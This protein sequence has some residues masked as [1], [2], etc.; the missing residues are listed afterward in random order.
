[1]CGQIPAGRPPRSCSDFYTNAGGCDTNDVHNDMSNNI[2]NNDAE[3]SPGVVKRRAA[4]ATVVK[5]TVEAS[6]AN[7]SFVVEHQT[8]SD[9]KAPGDQ[10]PDPEAEINKLEASMKALTVVSTMDA[11]NKYNKF[12]M[13]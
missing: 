5:Q 12:K 8:L 2:D 4:N 9:A 11:R 3:S 10:G 13:L 1:M 6:V 7:K